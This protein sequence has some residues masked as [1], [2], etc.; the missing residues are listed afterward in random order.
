MKFEL[1]TVKHFYEKDQIAKYEKLGFTFKNENS[2]FTPDAD[3]FTI[4]SYPEIEINT[5]DDLMF[6]AE[7]TSS[8]L[9]LSF[10]DDKVNLENILTI[11]DGFLE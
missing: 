6:I 1:T 8:D 7:T 11:K 4:R 9:I 2:P 5:L 10:K 3:L